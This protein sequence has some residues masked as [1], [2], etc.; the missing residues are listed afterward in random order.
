MEDLKK[1]GKIGFDICW[2]QGVFKDSME[3]YCPVERES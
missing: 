1:Q 2:Y 3:P